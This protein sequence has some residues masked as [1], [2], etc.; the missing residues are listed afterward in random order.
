[1]AREAGANK[2]FFA[3]AAPPVRS[4]NMYGIDMPTQSELIATGRSTEQVAREIGA[5]GL[6]YQ[7]LE[8]LEQSIRDLNPAMACFESSCFNG[9][10]VTGDIDADYLARLSQTRGAQTVATAGAD[11][12]A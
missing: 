8:D 9:E 10:Y 2:V 11:D 3:S 1:M 4:P 6:V 12:E 7:Q 5:D